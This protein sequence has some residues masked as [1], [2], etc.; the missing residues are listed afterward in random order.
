MKIL[1][2]ECLAKSTSLILKEV[3]Y[4]IIKVEDRLN[5]GIE[6]IKIF[7]YAVNQK[8]P[9]ITHDKGF[10]ILYHFTQLKPPTIIILQILSP[11]PEATNKLLSKFLS[12]FDLNKSKNYG[13]L[14]IISKNNI[15]IRSK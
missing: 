1:I 6:D 7:E 15:R 3:G 5:P 10:G 8:I 4:E 2:D 14:I 9:F 12:Q 13:K 11:H